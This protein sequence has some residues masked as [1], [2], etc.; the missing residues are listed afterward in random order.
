MQQKLFNEFFLTREA[1]RKRNKKLFKKIIKMRS[2]KN[3]N[4]FE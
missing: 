2:L 1:K 4:Y 3:S